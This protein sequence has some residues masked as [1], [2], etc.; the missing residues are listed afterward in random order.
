MRLEKYL[1]LNK[2]LLSL[3]GVHSISDLREELKNKKEGFDNDGRSFFVDTLIGLKNLKIDPNNLLQ[4]DSAIKEYSERL[5][6]HR[7]ENIV[8]KYFQYLAV[9]FAEIYLDRYFNRKQELIFDLNSFLEGYNQSERTE[10]SLF[11]DKDLKKLAYSMATGSGKTLIMHINYWQF[12]KYNTESLDNIIM[13]TPNEGLSKQHYNEMQRSGVPCRLY[14]ENPDSLTLHRDQ[15]F[16]IDIH[17]LTE[18]K[19]G[20]GVRVETSYFEGRNLVFIDEGHKGQTTEEQRWKKLREDLGKY[21]FVF[22]YSATFEQ[23]IDEKN[24]ELL[25]EY[26]KA[27]L[28]DYSYRYFYED[29]YGK[30]FYVY[31]LREDSF[32]RNYKDLILTANLLSFYEQSLLYENYR[33]ELKGYLIEKP[34]WAFIGSKVSGAGVN[35]DVLKVVLFLKKVVEDKTFL[36]E[37]ITKILNGKSGLRDQDGNDIFKD[38]FQHIRKNGYK[39]NEIYRRLFNA[40]GGTLQLCELKS[41]DGE[42]GLKIGE[43]DYFGVINIG[44]VSSFKKLLAKS[45]FEEKTDSFTPSLFERI[46]ENNSNI[47]ILIGA[48]KF[49][50]GWDSWRVCSMG[51]INMGKGEG[52]QIIQ[53]FG[54]GVRLK[55][56]ELSLK[57]SDENKYQIKSLETLN[58]FG[59]NADYINSFLETIRKE[60]VEY[61][62]LKIPMKRLDETKWKKLYTLKTDQDFDFTNHFI[63]FE[64]DENLLRTIKIDIRPRI[65]LAHGLVSAQGETEAERMYLGEYIDLLNWNNIYH[66]IL[67]YKISKGLSNLRLC[68]DVLPEIIRSRNYKVYAFPE[69]VCPRKFLDLNNLEEIILVMLK[70]YIDKFYTYKLRQTETKQMQFSF[71]VKEDDNLSYDQYTLKIEIPKDKK[72]RQKRKQEIEKIKKLLKQVDKLYQK[73]I[74][75]IPTLHF[76]R[77]LYTPLVVYDKHKEFVKSEPGKLNDGET[78]FIRGLRDYLKKSKVND[79]EVFLLRNLSRRGI[80]FFQNLGFYPDFIM[81]IKKDEEQTMVFIDPKGIRNLGNFNDEKIQLHKTIKEIEK[82]I[83]FDKEPSKL[84]LE[85][86]ILS[87]SNYDDIKK[88]FGEGNIPKHDF[89]EHHILFMEDEDLIDKIFRNIV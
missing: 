25:E 12:L 50:E 48:K 49:I 42:I 7:R 67:N 55:G 65:K 61:E 88:T 26:S 81:W 2:Y 86:L 33:D 41:A 69:Q 3:F 17:K 54:R 8:L 28:F 9:L 4:Y 68:K 62:E 21:G 82:E 35:S 36:E 74:D 32:T 5:S 38:R 20:A 72:E 84:R 31:N 29:G 89:E 47:N 23:V 64:I 11:E 15:V 57:R 85:S 76:D 52:P 19:K 18:E 46:N 83:K 43:A 58:I 45:R 60:E 44:D 13:V 10:I 39:I 77:H 56:R 59:L 24:K 73:D 75:E 51:L 63:E 22:E 16:I 70:S 40:N 1:I 79:R 66:K 30:D 71:M 6:K 14:S 27:I 34:L 37:I 53:L 80:K 87:I 78:R